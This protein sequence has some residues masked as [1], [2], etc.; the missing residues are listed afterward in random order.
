MLFVLLIHTSFDG[1]NYP[2]ATILKQVRSKQEGE[3]YIAKHKAM[4]IDRLSEDYDPDQ[5]EDND[6]LVLCDDGSETFTYAIEGLSRS[7]ED[8]NSLL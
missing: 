5:I 6:W 2:E 3:Q 4:L 8:I 7:A 1:P